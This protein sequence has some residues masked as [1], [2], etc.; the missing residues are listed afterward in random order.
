MATDAQKALDNINKI[1]SR[2]R[3]SERALEDAQRQEALKD[4]KVLKEREKTARR[5]TRRSQDREKNLQPAPTT[6]QSSVRGEKI[7]QYAESLKEPLDFGIDIGGYKIPS[8]VGLLAS[9]VGNFMR[10]KIYDVLQRGGTPIYDDRGNI[11]GVRDQYNRL[12]G[13]DP[14][15]QRLA[16]MERMDRDRP[17]PT[18]FLAMAEPAPVLTPAPSFNMVDMT[19]PYQT[20][21]RYYR[22][23]ML[24]QPYGL[25]DFYQM[26]GLEQPQSGFSSQPMYASP[27]A[28][29]GYSLLT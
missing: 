24:D 18:N 9:G 19:L 22:P 20:D 5:I 25:L 8:T 23:S 27:Y 13:R 3:T 6:T 12:T 4:P 16:M 2:N 26:Y 28:Y 7:K 14:E 1:I 29:G 11:V 10:T 15:A 21:A 17:E